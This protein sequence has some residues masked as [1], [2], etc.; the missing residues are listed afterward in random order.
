[1][2]FLIHTSCIPG[3]KI[4]SPPTKFMGLPLGVHTK[5]NSILEFPFRMMSLRG[6]K[7]DFQTGKGNISTW[8]KTRSHQQFIG[9]FAYT[10]CPYSQCQFQF[11]KGLTNYIGSSYGWGWVLS[12]LVSSMSSTVEMEGSNSISS[13]ATPSPLWCNKRIF[14][15]KSSLWLGNRE[16]RSFNLVKWSTITWTKIKW[17]GVK[18]FICRITRKST[19]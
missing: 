13:V 8:G 16:K 2:N 11:Q 1:M 7:R 10:L 4:D 19:L 6:V 15:I 14:I 3:C 12:N 17:I 18:G 9:L 5:F